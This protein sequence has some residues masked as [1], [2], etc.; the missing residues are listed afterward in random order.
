V[1]EWVSEFQRGGKGEERMGE[2]KKQHIPSPLPPSHSN[3]LAKRDGKVLK[4]KR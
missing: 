3:G 4:I 2:K 1:G